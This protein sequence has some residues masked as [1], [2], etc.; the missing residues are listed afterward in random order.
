MLTVEL[1]IGIILQLIS[2]SMLHSGS[3]VGSSHLSQPEHVLQSL[4]NGRKMDGL[5]L[6]CLGLG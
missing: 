2:A 4:A 3:L 6:G 1:K 5:A